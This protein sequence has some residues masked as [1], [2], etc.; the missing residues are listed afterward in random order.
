VFVRARS[1]DE[2]GANQPVFI[3]PEV[4]FGDRLPFMKDFLDVGVSATAQQKD[5]RKIL[6]VSAQEFSIQL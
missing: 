5:I 6:R 3:K 4:L 1:F 2:L